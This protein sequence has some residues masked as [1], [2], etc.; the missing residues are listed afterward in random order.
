MPAG[1][2]RILVPNSSHQCPSRS[3]GIGA[4]ENEA[5]SAA[6]PARRPSRR[7]AIF[8]GVVVCLSA[9]GPQLSAICRGLPTRRL[10][11]LFRFTVPHHIDTEVL[12]RF[13]MGR[14]IVGKSRHRAHTESQ[15]EVDI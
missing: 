7:G 5:T 14:C 2:M 12:S 9:D 15:L 13:S 1:S 4:D 8:L 11:D 6:D 10:W 3:T